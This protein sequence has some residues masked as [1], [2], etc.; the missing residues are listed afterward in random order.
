[1]TIAVTVCELRDDPKGFARDWEGLAEHVRASGSD[2]VVLPEMPFFPWF[3]RERRYDPATWQAAVAAHESWLARLEEL[4]PALVI[5]SRPVEAGGRRLNE[6]FLWEPGAGYRA[7]HTKYYLPEEDG[8]WEASWYH[9]GDGDFTPVDAARP[10]LRVG[11]LIC[12]ELWFMQRARAYGQAGIHLLAVPRATGKPTVDKWLAGGRVAAVVAGAFCASSNHVSEDPAVD[13]GG[14]GWLV[15]P[16]GRVLAV[17]SRA[18]PWVTARID[19]QDA[20]RAKATY[21]R[22]VPD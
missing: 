5:G 19:P 17:T 10:P 3:T 20:A 9:R 21:P 14:L 7:A 11:V 16:D 22:Y 15:D 6:G 12:T 4:A 18:T 1:M 8:F 2:V 13:L